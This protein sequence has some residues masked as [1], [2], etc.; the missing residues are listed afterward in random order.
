MSTPDEEIQNR[1]PEGK[2]NRREKNGILAQKKQG[3]GSRTW[4]GF[5]IILRETL[6]TTLHLLERQVPLWPEWPKQL[7]KRRSSLDK[8]DKIWQSPEHAV[9]ANKWRNKCWPPTLG[10]DEESV[11][12]SQ[13][14]RT[15][16]QYEDPQKAMKILPLTCLADVSALA[17][18]ELN[19]VL[20]LLCWAEIWQHLSLKV[21]Q[22]Q[23]KKLK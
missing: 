21:K 1:R 5:E 23:P 2:S 7:T 18:P 12:Q 4:H 13:H 20:Q 15:W 3:A 16:L 22:I 17:R 9:Q 10:E 6:Q 11:K 8:P 14:L 19:S